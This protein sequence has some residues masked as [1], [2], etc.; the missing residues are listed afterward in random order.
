M[1]AG[2]KKEDQEAMLAAQKQAAANAESAAKSNAAPPPPPA[3][4]ANSW[5]SQPMGSGFGGTMPGATI[6]PVPSWGTPLTAPAFGEVVNTSSGK[7]GP[8]QPNHP[9]I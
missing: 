8:V 7:P 2:T 6:N 5:G 9:E 1:L 4:V 3:P